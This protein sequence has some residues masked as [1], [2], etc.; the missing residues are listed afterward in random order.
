M[1]K[2]DGKGEPLPW[3]AT[4]WEWG[5]DF[6][7][8]TFELRQGVKF[9]DGTEFKSDAVKLAT[10]FVSEAKLTNANDWDRWEVLGDYSIRLY[11]KEYHTDFW[12]T[13][14]GINMSFFSPTAYA[15]HG[16]EWITEHPVGTGPFLFES[17]EKD[18]SLKVVRNPN[19]WQEGKPYLDG[20]ETLI[21]KDETTRSMAIQ[22]GEGDVTVLEAAKFLNDMKE[23]GFTVLA[24]YGGTDFVMFDTMNEG[25]IYNDARIRQAIEYA[26]D[27]ETIAD[28]LG[29]GYYVA[30]NQMPPPDNPSHN[31]DLPSR[32]Y[33]PEKS[34]ELLA[35]AGYPDGFPA[36]MI[37]IGTSPTAQILQEELK[38]VGIDVTFESVDNAK[39]WDYNMKG[40]E[41]AMVYVGF[42]VGINYPAW[43]KSYF[44]PTG[45]FDASV[46]LPDAILNG[47]APALSEQDPIK[48]KQMSDELIRLTWESAILVPIYSNALGNVLS[49][50][51]HDTGYFQY[52]DFSIWDPEL[53]WMEK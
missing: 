37:T 26:I 49:P 5:P 3:L 27:K 11:L 10:G 13:M 40:W 9:S 33:N 38:A 32:E 41:N 17:F 53:V 30:N 18:V 34:K 35:E 31:N 48:A 52:S 15:E 14:T 51:V 16:K 23:M 29:Y 2:T 25:S 20:I 7:Y 44:P 36:N 24:Q 22:S 47:I 21:V 39:F 12:S 46:K 50:K 4:D 19:Y 45:I 42:A 28:A 8:I 6:E 43:L 1:V